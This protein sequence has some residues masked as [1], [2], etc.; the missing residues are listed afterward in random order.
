MFGGGLAL[1]EAHCND[2]GDYPK[3]P[4]GGV[5]VF[6]DNL[7]LPVIAQVNKFPFNRLGLGAL[8]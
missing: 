4:K 2:Y 6:S 1:M 5:T 7:L 3:Q 8:V